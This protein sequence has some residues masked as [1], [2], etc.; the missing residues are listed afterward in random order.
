M[1]DVHLPRHGS[2]AV[3]CLGH[4]SPRLRLRRESTRRAGRLWH[5]LERIRF[6][7]GQRLVITISAPR[8]RSEPIQ[9]TFRARRTPRVKRLTQTPR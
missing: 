7:S 2:V 3:E 4:R 1:F 8:L 6:R 5:E 9:L